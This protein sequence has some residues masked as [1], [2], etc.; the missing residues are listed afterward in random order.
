M[1]TQIY[2][3]QFKILCV[4]DLMYLPNNMFEVG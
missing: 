1:E 3:V 4:N 2:K